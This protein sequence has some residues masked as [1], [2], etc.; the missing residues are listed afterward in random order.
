MKWSVELLKTPDDIELIRS[1]LAHSGYAIAEATFDPEVSWVLT[2]PK[3]EEYELATLVRE[4]AVQLKTKLFRIG[5]LEEVDL[6]V[7]VGD[8]WKQ[9]ADGSVTN[10]RSAK[11]V[12][13]E[14][15]GGTMKS[16]PPSNP[17][18]SEEERARLVEAQRVENARKRMAQISRIAAAIDNPVVVQ[19]MK[20]LKVSSLSMTQAGHIVDLI[21]KDL[22]GDLGAFATKKQLQRFYRSINHPDIMGLEA[23]HAVSNKVP[24]SKP[25]TEHEARSFARQIGQKWLRSHE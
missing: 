4:D 6:N 25:M 14:V 5:L 2:H 24:P 20:L 3:Y 17:H 12:G 21:K 22:D 23:R 9:N 11:L 13:G 10:H 1:A 16:G 19:I 8:L 7:D 15:D 18:L